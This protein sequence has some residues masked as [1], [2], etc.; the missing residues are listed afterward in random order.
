MQCGNNGIDQTVL[1]SRRAEWGSGPRVLELCG[2]RQRDEK[3]GVG[4]LARYFWEGKG[5]CLIKRGISWL[6]H[7]N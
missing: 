1:Q 2:Q 7:S 4:N 3:K 5:P 6:A